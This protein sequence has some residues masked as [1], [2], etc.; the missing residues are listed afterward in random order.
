M[1]KEGNIDDIFKGKLSD[2][3]VAPSDAVWGRIESD[4]DNKPRRKMFW[5]FSI[6]ILLISTMA[7]GGFFYEK[8]V[9]TIAEHTETTNESK[10]TATV[11]E[12]NGLTNN[13]ISK[14]TS[15]STLKETQN[16]SPLP[17]TESFSENAT[18]KNGNS[19]TGQLE[20]Q[21]EKTERK[22]EQTTKIKRSGASSNVNGLN[23]APASLAIIA[24]SN[25][26][27]N[28]PAQIFSDNPESAKRQKTSPLSSE[29]NSAFKPE[30]M[31]TL[32]TEF[33]PISPLFN[34]SIKLNDGH[35]KKRQWMVGLYAGVN[36][37]LKYLNYDSKAQ[38]VVVDSVLSRELNTTTFSYGALVTMKWNK[39]WRL[40]TGISYS[41]WCRKA[42]YPLDIPIDQNSIATNPNGDYSTELGGPTGG[43]NVN[44]PNDQIPD[45]EILSP[46]PANLEFDLNVDECYEI[47]SIPLRLGYEMFFSEFS[48]VP[49]IGVG[50]NRIV[51]NSLKADASNDLD[52]I[53]FERDESFNKEMFS[54]S[55]SLGIERYL[56]PQFKIGLNGVYQY[57]VT[58]IY[59]SNQFSTHP[60]T[61]SGQ[62]R[63]WYIFSK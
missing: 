1:S 39:H 42:V 8:P 23:S 19:Q 60:Y 27:Q 35:E 26:A 59:K 6:A 32:S 15:T 53:D 44:I 49:E 37:N 25:T 5:I 38:L 21:A 40:T 12:T 9:N 43:Q 55:G 30:F 4:L 14:S 34:Q 52:P 18:A 57:N 54:V 31:N 48:L 41:K 24:V 33:L 10:N 46:I 16:G 22:K 58:P 50:Y 11:E 56:S 63:L 29:T 51:G 36:W 7:I 13:Q 47:V 17:L 2:L 62:V 3:E 28:N 61:I 45:Y 20:Q